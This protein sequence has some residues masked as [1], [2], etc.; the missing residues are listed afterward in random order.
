MLERRREGV[1]FQNSWNT[2]FSSPVPDP[3]RGVS[4]LFIARID[5]VHSRLTR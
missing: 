2:G 4:G 3:R 1:Q 5:E